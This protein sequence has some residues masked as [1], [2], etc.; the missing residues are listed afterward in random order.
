MA[1]ASGHQLIMPPPPTTPQTSA[2]KRKSL[3]SSEIKQSETTESENIFMPKE[4]LVSIVSGMLCKNCFRDCASVRY[5][6]HQIDVYVK[7][8][9]SECKHVIF[10]STG[11]AKEVKKKNFHP[12]TLLLVYSMMV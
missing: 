8:Q 12:K 9:C 4:H 7:V 2:L 6:H 1:G 5:I 11:K 10:D 3:I